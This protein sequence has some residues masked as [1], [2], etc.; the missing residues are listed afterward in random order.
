MAHWHTLLRARAIE[1]QAFV[2]AA[3]QGGMH[4][5]GRETFGHSLIVSP[6]GELLGE[7]GVHPTVIVADVELQL[8]EDVRRRVPSLQH[9]RA[10]DVVHAAQD[11]SDKVVP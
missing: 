9:D 2:F 11:A 6:W 4:E 5:N 10:F 7:A 8:L 3:A 1:S